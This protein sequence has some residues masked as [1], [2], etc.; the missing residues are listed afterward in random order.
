MLATALNTMVLVREFGSTA[1]MLTGKQAGGSARG[2]EGPTGTADRDEP[3][4]ASRSKRSRARRTKAYC[5]RRKTSAGIIF[6]LPL[7]QVQ[8]SV[9]GFTALEQGKTA[10]PLAVLTGTAAEEG[11]RSVGGLTDG[12]SASRALRARVGARSLTRGVAGADARVNLI[13]AGLAALTLSLI[14]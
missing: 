10:N 11:E 9:D 13:A 6:K 14:I 8:R 4:N 1:R 5:G 7:G 2:Y 3:C 12:A